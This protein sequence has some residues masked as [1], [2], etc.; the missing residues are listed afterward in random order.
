MDCYYTGSMAD[1]AIAPIASQQH[2]NERII[3]PYLRGITGVGI[4]SVRTCVVPCTKILEPTDSFHEFIL[5]AD[6][7]NVIDLSGIMMQVQGR[8]RKKSADNLRY[9]DLEPADSVCIVSNSM[10][11][12]FS[13]TSMTV[14][15]NQAEW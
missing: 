8:M 13:S 10:Y 4:S 2:I 15:G 3:A 7:R 12:L 11:S 6:G 5:P 1:S 14:G 9:V